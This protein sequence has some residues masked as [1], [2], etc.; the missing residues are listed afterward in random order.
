MGDDKFQKIV[1]YQ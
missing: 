1:K